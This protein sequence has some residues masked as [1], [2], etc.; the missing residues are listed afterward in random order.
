MIK[1]ASDCSIRIFMKC[2]FEH[3]VSDVENFDAIWTEYVDISGIGE[4]K[5]MDLL[6]A[7]H[8]IQVRLIIIPAMIQFQLD[9]IKKFDEPYKDGFWFFKKYGHKL[10]WN[11]NFPLAFLKQLEFVQIKEKKYYAESDKLEKELKD[12]KTDGVVKDGKERQQFIKL[13]IAVGKPYMGGIDRDKTDME[14]YGMMVRDYFDS[15]K[16]AKI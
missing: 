1:K 6:V 8:N 2:L 13:L 10:I 14:T 7:I 9:Y 5:E 11:P 4:T 3:D 12:L 15:V 16:E